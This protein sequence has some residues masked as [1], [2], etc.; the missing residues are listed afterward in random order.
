MRRV[1]ILAAWLIAGCSYRPLALSSRVGEVN[2]GVGFFSAEKPLVSFANAAFVD[3]DRAPSCRLAHVDACEVRL[4]DRTPVEVGAGRI[5]ITGG[6]Q[7]IV[8]MPDVSD[9]LFTSYPP[10]VDLDPLPAWDRDATLNVAGEGGVEVAAF[11]AHVT[12]PEP[13]A[14][15]EPRDAVV[16]S[17]GQS[18]QFSWQSV[19]GVARFWIQTVSTSHE[20]TASYGIECTFD[21]TR[22]SGEVAAAALAMLPA[23]NATIEATHQVSTM[24]VV[25]GWPLRVNGVHGAVTPDG[26]RYLANLTIK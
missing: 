18:L 19:S 9:P 3:Y 1:A 4:C 16:V 21:A 13:I 23:Q 2:V 10:Y 26:G 7:T 12:V 14:I 17:P 11:S 5:E 24:T 20:Q 25:G 8:L 15:T 22:G 6:V